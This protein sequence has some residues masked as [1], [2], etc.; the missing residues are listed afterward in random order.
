V[1]S[2]SPA[3]TVLATL[4]T[5]ATGTEDIELMVPGTDGDPAPGP[6][7]V[8]AVPYR[9]TALARAWGTRL[10]D[11]LA[12]ALAYLGVGLV[13]VGLAVIAFTWARVAGTLDVAL[14]LPYIASG[15]FAGIGLVIV[16]SAVIVV[17]ARRRDAALRAEQ[18]IELR[19]VLATIARRLDDPERDGR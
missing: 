4:R 11:P 19:E 18:L 1:N 3:S 15:G 7:E 12:P 9:R 16:G 10:L 5:V 14:Q 2:P 6:A 8:A 13:V 17:A